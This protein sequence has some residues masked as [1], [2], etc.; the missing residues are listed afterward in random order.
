MALCPQEQKGFFYLFKELS[1]GSGLL[2]Y[3]R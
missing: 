2:G 3:L 1:E